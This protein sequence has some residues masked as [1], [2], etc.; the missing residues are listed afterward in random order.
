[1]RFR[2]RGSNVQL[3]SVK[4]FFTI[5][6]NLFSRIAYEETLVSD[7]T[8]PLFGFSAWPWGSVSKGDDNETARVFYNVWLNFVT[9][10]EFS[11]MDQWNVLEAPDRKT[12]R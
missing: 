6:R 3:T 11:W 10:K 9:S 4:D 7:V 12:R 5:Y 8:Y 2:Y 1:M